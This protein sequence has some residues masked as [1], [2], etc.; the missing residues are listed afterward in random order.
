MTNM[1]SSITNTKPQEKNH[2]SQQLIRKHQEWI[3]SKHETKE[4]PVPHSEKKSH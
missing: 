2:Q 3:L 1:A 4:G